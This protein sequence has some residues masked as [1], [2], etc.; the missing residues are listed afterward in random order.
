LT[1]RR[2]T[3]TFPFEEKGRLRILYLYASEEGIRAMAQPARSRCSHPARS[4]S[5]RET[6]LPPIQAFRDAGVA[7]AA[8]EQPG[9]LAN[10]LAA[11]DAQ[12]SLH[13]VPVDAGGGGGRVTRHA[14]S[15]L[16][17]A[18]THGALEGKAADLAIWDIDHRPSSPTASAATLAP[19]W[20][21]PGSP[22]PGLH[23]SISLRMKP[24][25]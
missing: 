23:P 16:G 8:T 25:C 6:R 17:M 14:A 3:R 13:S 1:A 2:F 24:S 18:G 20:S 21:A 10:D 22:C 11:A 12:H 4:T 9:Q 5:L 7:M 19:A 15:A